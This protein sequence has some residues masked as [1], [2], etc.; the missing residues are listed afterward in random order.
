MWQSAAKNLGEAIKAHKVSGAIEDTQAAINR[1]TADY[2]AGKRDQ[3]RN[4]N[5]LQ[6]VI[7]NISKGGISKYIAAGGDASSVDNIMKAW[8]MPTRK[9]MEDQKM[10]EMEAKLRL[11]LKEEELL[12]PSRE[13]SQI[14]VNAASAQNRVNMDLQKQAIEERKM[15]E[16]SV[17][18]GKFDP[19]IKVTIDDVKAVKQATEFSLNLNKTY[20]KLEGLINN[21]QIPF[22]NLITGKDKSKVTALTNQLMLEAKNLMQMGAA[23]SENEARLVAAVVGTTDL[24]DLSE[25]TILDHTVAFFA[26][27][28]KDPTSVRELMSSTV[29]EGKKYFNERLDSV[30]QAHNF[31]RNDT[32]RYKTFF[33]DKSA[34][35]NASQDSASTQNKALTPITKPA[36][37]PRSKYMK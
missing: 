9:Q 13:A 33:Q 27:A 1:A 3:A 12:R 6:E 4:E 7:M 37:K 10:A 31:Y 11:K 35:N 18:Y 22:E 15:A 8:N 32:D 29:K 26:K 30:D 24:K 5:E 14:R 25:K 2:A 36:E 23:L 28:E 17:N 34:A 16:K 19:N 21:E 20:D